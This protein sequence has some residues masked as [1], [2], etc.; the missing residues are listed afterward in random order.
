MGSESGCRFPGFLIFFMFTWLLFASLSQA[1]EFYV[2]GKDGWVTKPSE[3]YHHWAQ[4]MRFQVN[5]T[6]RFKYQK[7][8]DS[9]LV[10]KKEDYDSCNTKNPLQKMEDGDSS[11]ILNRSGPFYFISGKSEHCQKG[12]KLI[13]V[14]MAARGK[15]HHQSPPTPA[16]APAPVV[17]PSPA[18][19]TPTSSPSASS[20]PGLR[21]AGPVVGLASGVSLGISL[22]FGSIGGLL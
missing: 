8:S 6:L 15:P 5:D 11:F 12:Q 21:L 18:A 4:R 7:G 1:R 10:V 19:K 14:V 3:D 16:P 13:V 22:I 2:G 17:A 9:V 20:G